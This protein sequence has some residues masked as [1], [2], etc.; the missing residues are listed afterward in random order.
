MITPVK[1]IYRLS[2]IARILAHHDALFPLEDT[3]I[4][5]GMVMAVRLLVRRKAE[6]RPGERLARALQELGPSFIKLGQALSTRSDL[7]GEE[8]AADLSEL[9]DHLPPF[10]TS[11]AVAI[12]EQELEGRLEDLFLTFE[13]VPIAAASIAQVH[14]A[15]TSEGEEVAVKVLRPGIEMAFEKD[16]E[17]LL[18]VAKLIE[19]TRPE[20]RRLKPVKI[21]QTFQETVNLEMDLRLEAAAANEIEQNFN[22]DPSYVVPS[23]DWRRTSR[24]VLTAK[25]IQGIPIDERQELIEKG[26]DPNDILARAATAL[27]KQVFRDG[28]FHADQH[29]GNLFVGEDGEIIAVDFGIMGR[30]DIPTRRYLG[31]MLLSFL[32]RDYKRVAEI[33]FEAGYVPAHKSV[34]AFTQA[35]RSIAEPILDKPQNEISIARLLA[36]LFQVTKTFEMET[37]PQLLLLQKTMLVAEGVGRK[38]SPKMNVWLL[39]NPLIED[40]VSNNLGPEKL[41]METVDEISDTLRKLPRVLSNLEKNATAFTQGGIKLHPDTIHQMGYTTSGERPSTWQSVVLVL[42]AIFI[43]LLILV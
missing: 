1:N 32:T 33:H 11:E 23:V 15:V 5:M 18:W 3:G 14:S 41:I 12:I 31:E 35:C 43:A 24:R 22:D 2:Q 17:L 37:Q 21:I 40:W 8:V 42:I 36:Q 6:G 27:F 26:F 13:D 16:L 9:Q 30:L 20:F 25:R 7:L 29:P 19:R 28:F 34:H 39:A 10:K 38:I 4:A